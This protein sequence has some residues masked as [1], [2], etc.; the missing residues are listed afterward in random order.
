MSTPI[1]SIDNNLA[2]HQEPAAIALL[3]SLWIGTEC[4]VS[5]KAAHICLTDRQHDIPAALM[6]DRDSAGWVSG[7][8]LL[9]IDLPDN[10]APAMYT[11]TK[12][13]A[14][15]EVTAASIKTDRSYTTPEDDE[16]QEERESDI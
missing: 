10:T 6:E 1:H 2:M 4:W 5:D 12:C 8:T 16:R 13:G 14:Q 11:L 15:V 7:W 9:S 3:D